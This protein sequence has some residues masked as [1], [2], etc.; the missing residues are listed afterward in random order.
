MSFDADHDLII[1]NKI[2]IANLKTTVDTIQQAQLDI[3]KTQQELV[4]S[5][6][7]L[8]YNVGAVV[9]GLKQTK[10]ALGETNK[11]SKRID[12]LD[13]RILD[14]EE[15]TERAVNGILN[16]LVLINKAQMEDREAW[17]PVI[18]LFAHWKWM[19]GG[20]VGLIAVTGWDGLVTLIQLIIK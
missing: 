18:N 11:H 10:D 14:H 17:T 12:D 15:K 16:Q 8:T 2:E 1:T 13:D 5:L 4:L 3:Q 20:V 9:E 19:V 7:Q 6:N